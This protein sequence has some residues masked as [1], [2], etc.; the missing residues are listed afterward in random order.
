MV[1]M[2]ATVS[3]GRALCLL[4]CAAAESPVTTAEHC[5]HAGGDATSRLTGLLPQ[6]DDCDQLQLA[7]ADRVASRSTVA[8][9]DAA[10]P[11]AI[12]HVRYPSGRANPH[13]AAGPPPGHY[14][15]IGSHRP[16]RI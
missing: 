4:P 10:L 12:E 2:L 5:E 3:A 1:L 8:L 15:P 9:S 6:C 11:H 16:L 7:A 13:A 14:V